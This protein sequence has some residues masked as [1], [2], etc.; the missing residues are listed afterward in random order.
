MSKSKAY[1]VHYC[2]HCDKAWLDK[3]LTDVKT[4][5]PQWKLCKECCEKEGIDFDKQRPGKKLAKN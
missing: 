5:P 4:F 2:P 3:D 1:V